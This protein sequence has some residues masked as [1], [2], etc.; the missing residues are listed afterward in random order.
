MSALVAERSRFVVRDQWTGV[1]GAGVVGTVSG[2]WDE[3]RAESQ[4][5]LVVM[6][7][8]AADRKAQNNKVFI[9]AF[10]FLIEKFGLEAWDDLRQ[11]TPEQ[12]VEYYLTL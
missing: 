4:R 9:R 11:W 1:A 12:V 2:D 10:T 8:R 7:A 3:A 5:L 6:D